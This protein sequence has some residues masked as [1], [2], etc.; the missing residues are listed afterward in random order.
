MDSGTITYVP[1]VKLY[2]VKEKELPYGKRALRNPEKVVEFAGQ[3][4]ENADKEH[5]LVIAM[6]AKSKPVGLE[7]VAIGAVNKAA[8]ELRDIFKYA[9]L[10]NAF[11][12]IVVH[13]HPS[14][15]PDPSSEDCVLTE[16][17]QEAGGLLGI[18][19]L[20]HIILG[21]EGNYFSF[22]ESSKQIKCRRKKGG[23]EGCQQ[24]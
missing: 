18:P 12:I 21:E 5:V 23:N 19:L 9:I 8:V 4:L 16:K 3:F 24:M 13:N 14:G 1:L 20:D 10:S 17:V 6:D 15:N 2:A 11:G 7:V 22:A